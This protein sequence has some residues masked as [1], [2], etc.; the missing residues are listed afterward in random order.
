MLSSVSPTFV[1]VWLLANTLLFFLVTH[2]WDWLSNLYPIQLSVLI[3]LG[4]SFLCLISCS[5][6]AKWFGV[7]EDKRFTFCLVYMVF[8]FFIHIQY[9]EYRKAN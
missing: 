6:I 1:I 8:L 7:D 2:F 5:F 3:L 9:Y 4:Y